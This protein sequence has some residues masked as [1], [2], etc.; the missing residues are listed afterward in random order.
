MFASWRPL[1]IAAFML[2]PAPAAAAALAP[3]ELS[4]LESLLRDLGFDPGPVDGLV[5]DDTTDAIRRYQD[6]ALL[7][8]EPEPDQRLLDELDG[9][10]P[11]FAAL[12][13]AKAR[14]EA[15][16]EGKG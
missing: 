1:L 9:A 8:G 10:P 7:P 14:P 2:A 15:G 13:P 4:E 3:D 11:A 16:R 5:D 12:N 6:F